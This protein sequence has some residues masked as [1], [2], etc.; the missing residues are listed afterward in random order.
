MIEGTWLIAEGQ[1]FPVEI[2]PIASTTDLL[3]ETTL[4]RGRDV[5]VDRPVVFKTVTVTDHGAES[6][7]ILSAV[8][9]EAQVVAALGEAAT[10]D[11]PVPT[12]YHLYRDDRCVT[13][14][15]SL[16]PGRPLGTFYHLDEDRPLPDAA[17]IREIAALG[18]DICQALRPL[19]SKGYAH[20]DVSPKNIMVADG[21]GRAQAALIDF[22]LA[23]VARLRPGLTEGEG[24]RGYRAP[25]QSF[26]RTYRTDE[27]RATAKL[28]PP[29]G[30]PTDVY[31]LAVVLYELLTR[32]P[33]GDPSPFEPPPHPATINPAIPSALGDALIG[34]LAWDADERPRI[35]TF[36]AGLRHAVRPAPHPVAPAPASVP[37]PSSALVDTYN[38]GIVAPP[39]AP[40]VSGGPPQ[41]VVATLRPADDQRTARRQLTYVGACV[42]ALILIVVLLI[43]LHII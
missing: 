16:V 4:Y 32:A 42:A 10:R 14:K 29:P 12:I 6:H 19:H 3:V 28:P 35:G 2:P 37:A 20:R 23:V 13:I 15:M 18:M 11:V 30:P 38:D 21:R 8:V 40:W 34:A 17:Q 43:A 7:R 5:A 36:R 1:R 25:E 26:F 33:L 41:T 31:S 39:P 22:G 24:T 27:D 9:R